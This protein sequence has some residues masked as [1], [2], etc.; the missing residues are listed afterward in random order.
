LNLDA[1]TEAGYSA[2]IAGLQDFWFLRAGCLFA[3]HTQSKTLTSAP[4]LAGS[5]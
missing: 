3:G 2:I 1:S 5:Y 4:S